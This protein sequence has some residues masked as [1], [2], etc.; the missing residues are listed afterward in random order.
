ML[1]SFTVLY[2]RHL[3][4]FLKQKANNNTMEL[5]KQVVQGVGWSIGGAFASIAINLFTKVILARLLFPGDFGLF[6]MVFII[7]A[8][9]NLFSGLGISSTLIY[10][11]TDD[12]KTINTAF[13]FAIIIGIV[14]TVL[15]YISSNFVADF[16]KQPD[17]VPM[18]QIMSF[19]M[20]FD[21]LANFFYGIIIKELKFREKT[22]AEV[23]VILFYGIAVIG[24][25]YLGLGVWSMVYAYVFQH[26]FLLVFLWAFCQKKL[27]FSINYTLTKEIFHFGKY[28]TLSS[29]LA[30]AITSV[31]NILIGRKLGDEKLGYYSFGFNIATLPMLWITHIITSVCSPVYAKLK[32][33]AQLLQ[34]A[35]EKSLE[36]S[37]IFIFPISFGILLLADIFVE[38]VFSPKWMPMVPILRILA[39]YSILRSVC[40]ICGYMLDS[41]GKPKVA[42][43]LVLV[44][45]F[46]LCL[47][48]YPAFLFFN[49]L[50][51]A[52]AVV[53]ARGISMILHLRAV[54]TVVKNTIKS[55]FQLLS[56]KAYATVIMGVCILLLRFF[57]VENTLIN[58]LFYLSIGTLVYA[59]ALFFL[60]RKIFTEVK[61][62]IQ[63]VL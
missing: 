27:K 10:K 50:G 51:V 19:V 36:W 14:L 56:K 28:I 1:G 42:S 9:L 15:C 49:V 5:K 59:F 38:V 39:V 60:E 43:M 34:K 58:F 32:H 57:L 33:D 25:A 2:R 53:L 62:L 30:W 21:S 17:L 40:N 37:M 7:I 11:N 29:L 12:E 35:Y 23:C 22:I 24:L 54:H 47:I 63:L 31:D 8:F 4:T 61:E 52:A 26:F 46:I 6:A 44:E 3:N 18:I 20:I 48:I 55:Y 16:F 41:V 13:V 45:L